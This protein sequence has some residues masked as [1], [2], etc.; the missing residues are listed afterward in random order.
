MSNEVK[1][2]ITLKGQTAAI[3]FQKPDCDPVFAKAEGDL[4]TVLGK[5]PELLETAEEG[6]GA[7]PRYPKCETDLKPPAPPTTTAPRSSSRQAAPKEQPPM[8]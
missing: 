8:F 6:W 2:V 5:I 3:G 4:P 7:N 1:I